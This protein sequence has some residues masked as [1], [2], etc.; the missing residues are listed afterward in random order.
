MFHLSRDFQLKRLIKYGEQIAGKQNGCIS[1]TQL[2]SVLKSARTTDSSVT[3]L[4][5]CNLAHIGYGDF[6]DTDACIKTSLNLG[7]LR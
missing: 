5:Q 1:H 3:I 7:C 4:T 2:N 6:S